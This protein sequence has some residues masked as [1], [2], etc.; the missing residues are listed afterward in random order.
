MTTSNVSLL[1]ALGAFTGVLAGSI[2]DISIEST[3]GLAAL[4]VFVES[5][6]EYEHDE[7]VIT[8]EN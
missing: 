3:L 1:A 6:F 5:S 4:A 8:N 7:L 2:T